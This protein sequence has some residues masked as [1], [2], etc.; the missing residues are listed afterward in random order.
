MSSDSADEIFDRTPK[1][2]IGQPKTTGSATMRAPVA[3]PRA[4]VKFQSFNVIYSPGRITS[5]PGSGP[6]PSM[7]IVTTPLKK[8]EAEIVVPVSS[9][10]QLKELTTTRTPENVTPK[11]TTP[12]VAHPHPTEDAKEDRR[13][14]AKS[15]T[16]VPKETEKVVDVL[17]SSSR[18]ESHADPKERFITE[19][20]RPVKTATN[21]VIPEETEAIETPVNPARREPP[22]E[23]SN[24]ERR[25][26]TKT[27][28][29]EVVPQETEQADLP[30]PSSRQESQG[31]PKERSNTGRRKSAKV[32]IIHQETK[33]IVEQ[34]VNSANIELNEDSNERYKT[35]RRRPAKTTTNVDIHQQTEEVVGQFVSS[36]HRE[37]QE[38]PKERSK[39]DRQRPAKTATSTPII[40]HLNAD[41][42]RPAKVSTNMVITQE[43]VAVDKPTSSARRDPRAGTQPET[44]TLPKKPKTVA[45][46]LSRQ[47]TPQQTRTPFK[48]ANNVVN[49]QGTPLRNTSSPTVHPATPLSSH[50]T[51]P[52][53]NSVIVIVLIF[54]VINIFSHS[55]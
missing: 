22:V 12:V 14:S 52:I 41:H 4:N 45:V 10:R 34:S 23:R 43:E 33:K 11:T 44:G 48:E 26:S 16:I 40:E 36:A 47:P 7:A 1:E 29:D 31:D 2:R 27:T 49:P 46:D 9:R 32:A 42:R 30:T 53:G 39:V 6:R 8:R 5:G 20:R 35:D 25:R 24:V 55:L 17:P 18:R 3:T 54:H 51:E 15:A 28:T 21:N 38:E 13:R 37:L 50:T 19:R